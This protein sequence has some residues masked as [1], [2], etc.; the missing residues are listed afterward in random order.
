MADAG[1]RGSAC[2]RGGAEAGI[3]EAILPGAGQ[4]GLKNAC[5]LGGGLALAYEIGNNLWD[6][7]PLNAYRMGATAVAGCTAG[8][9]LEKAPGSLGRSMIL[10]PI[11]KTLLGTFNDLSYRTLGVLI[12]GVAKM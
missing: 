7:E 9:Y 5:L 1:E 3:A 2:L 6:H 8:A 10:G 11:Y 4:V 12:E